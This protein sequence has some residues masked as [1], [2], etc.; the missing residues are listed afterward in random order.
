MLVNGIIGAPHEINVPY[1]VENTVDGQIKVSG[2]GS[3]PEYLW[4]AP[5]SMQYVKNIAYFNIDSLTINITGFDTIIELKL[6]FNNNIIKC[7][8]SCYYNLSNYD[9]DHK[10][11]QLHNFAAIDS[12]ETTTFTYDINIRYNLE[13]SKQDHLWVI[14]LLIVVLFISI[15]IS[16]YLCYPKSK[17]QTLIRQKQYDQINSV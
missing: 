16:I 17:I 8:H 1:K 9:L 13:I 7:N 11:L 14:I 15:C 4:L 5:N 6:L 3:T 12:N 10:F 2:V